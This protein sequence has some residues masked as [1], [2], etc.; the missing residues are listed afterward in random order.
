MLLHGG[1]LSLVASL[2]LLGCL[3]ANPRLLLQDYPA[4]IQAAVPPKTRDERRTALVVG[5]P[6]LAFLLLFPAWSSW[7]L[8]PQDGHAAPF[9]TLALNT[10]VVASTFN[11]ADWLVLDWLVF[12]AITPR[13]VVIPGTEG[14]P[15]YK[16]YA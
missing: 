11:V 10:F 4:A 12:C 3:L 7:T 5:I 1:V 16:D 2:Y 13:F 14:M 6:F 8:P 15:A 9:A